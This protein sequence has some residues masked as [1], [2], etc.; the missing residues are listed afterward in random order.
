MA[1]FPPDLL[2]LRWRAAHWAQMVAH[3]TAWAP[4][5]A[6]GLLAGVG[7]TVEAVYLVENLHHSPKTYEMNPTQ[8]VAAM[9]A[10]D[11]AGWDLLGIFHSHPRGPAHPSPTDIAYAY[12]PDAVYVILSPKS[13][14]LARGEWQGRGFY[15]AAGQVTEVTLITLPT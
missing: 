1:G 10:M 15:I 5:E 14:G 6:C 4:E 8:Q 11:E 3:V 7:R 9:T 13:E 2:A 12:Y